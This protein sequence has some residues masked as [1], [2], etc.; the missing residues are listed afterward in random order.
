MVKPYKAPKGINTLMIL[1]SRLGVGP[2]VVLITTGRRSGRQRSV[3]V[4]PIAVEGVE[5]LVAP[6]GAV[7][8]VGNARVNRRATMRKG[9]KSRDVELVE[10]TPDSAP[11]VAAYYER[12]R[13]P[14]PYMDLPDEPTLADFEEASGLFPVFRVQDRFRSL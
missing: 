10:V 11:V 2:T 6:Y 8:W 1:L 12:E 13:Y 9:R 4:S 14:R 7:G 3:P 5:Y